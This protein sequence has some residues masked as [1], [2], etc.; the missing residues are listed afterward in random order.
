MSDAS[1]GVV[2]RWYDTG[3]VGLLAENVAW[4]V[5]DAFFNGGTYVRRIA[6]AEQFFP[7]LKAMF[8]DYVAVP[9]MVLA[10]G[11]TVA[12][13]GVYRVRTL[14]GQAGEIAFAH[15]WT[16]SDGKIATFRQVADTAALGDLLNFGGTAS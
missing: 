2:R 10:D 11:E 5:L 4:S 1:S 15:V 16:V 14:A 12:T 9:N 3:D 7:A 13:K 8:T 6:V